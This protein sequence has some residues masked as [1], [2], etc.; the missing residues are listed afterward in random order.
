M[1]EAEAPP[2][3]SRARRAITIAFYVIV[4]AL[5]ALYVSRLDLGAL[6]NLRLDWTLLAAGLAAGLLQRMLLPLVWVVIVRDLGVTIRRYAAYNFV[7]AKAWLGRY[8]PGKVAMVAARV[9]FAEELGASRSVIGVSS[10]AEIGAY[11]L[12]TGGVGLIGVASLA[13]SMDVIDAYWP[14]ALAMVALLSVLLWP[15]VFNGGVRL[16]LRLLRRPVDGVPKVGFRTLLWAVGCSLVVSMLT[17]AV[18]VLLGGAV[19][20]AAFD[21]PLFLFG[22]YNLA[23]ALGMAFVIAPSGI[24]AREAIQ[25]P[26]FTMVLSPEAALAVVLLCRVAE[27]VTDGLFYGVSASWA[28]LSRGSS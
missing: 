27:V 16:L 8:V 18:A 4:A 10:I 26:L 5:L 21:H 1:S 28:R 3:P 14:F 9:Y 6:A 25:L 15:P 22:A 11:L 17:G 2:R 24:G 23:G 12:V 20:R 7:Y 13:G 19:D